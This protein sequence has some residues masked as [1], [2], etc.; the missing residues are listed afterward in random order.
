MVRKYAGASAEPPCGQIGFPARHSGAMVYYLCS[1]EKNARAKSAS[2]GNRSL[3]LLRASVSRAL[4][5]ELCYLWACGEAEH[6]GRDHVEEENPLLQSQS[7]H[8]RNTKR[9]LGPNIPI[10]QRTAPAT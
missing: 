1:T 6:D 8:P 4:I 5:R 3:F 9:R 7:K 10:I 2:K